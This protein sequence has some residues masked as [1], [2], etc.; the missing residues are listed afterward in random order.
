MT[1][2]YLV[3]ATLAAP[4]SIS[5]MAADSESTQSA[6]DRQATD[7][8][9][10]QQS[11]SRQEQDQPRPY[12]Q[13]D[14]AWISIDGTVDSVTANS[15]ALDYGTGEITVEMDDRDRD[16]EGYKLMKGD[17]VRV[18][19]RVDHNLLADTTIEASSVYVDNL[20]TYFFASSADDEDRLLT[21][22]WPL[23]VSSTT[24]RGTV[25][26]VEDD[27]FT[28]SS[29]GGDIR[30]E[31][32]KLA[33]D[34]LDENGYQRVEQGDFVLVRGD[35]DTEFFDTRRELQAN[36]IVVLQDASRNG[37]S[38]ERV[39]RADDAQRTQSQ[40]GVTGESRES[41]DSTPADF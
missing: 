10:S 18:T 6:M 40:S 1:L 2:K 23:E 38:D 33:Y 35:M 37:S 31:T 39:S 13:S 9:Q 16:A 28:V 5:A 17:M 21:N 29:P 20:G 15:F 32:Q 36:T 34:P 27:S 12:L 14:N 11:M 24:L 4:F 22:T 7:R 41:G 26:N 30:V 25:Q 8:Q 3:A 19:G